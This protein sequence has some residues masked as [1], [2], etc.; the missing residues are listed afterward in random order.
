MLYQICPDI[1]IIS[2]TWERKRI[3]LTNL[4][5]KTKFNSISY[6]RQ[7]RSGGGC[8]IIFNENRFNVEELNIAIPEGV[9]ATWGVLQCKDNSTQKF[10]VNKI[11][12]GGVY[13]SPKSKFKIETID[14]IIETIHYARAKFGNEVHFLLGGDFNRVDVN[15]ILDAYG[16]L[17][18]F[19]SVP[20]RK[21][22]ILE[23][24]LTDLHPFY[25]PPTTLAPLEVDPDKNGSNS[26]HD[27]VLLAPKSNCKFKD[28]R[29]KKTVIT[30]PIPE[31]GIQQFGEEITAHKWNEVIETENVDEK[32]ENFHSYI[33]SLLDKHLPEKTIT[34]S[35]LDRKWMSGDLK[36]LLRKKQRE[37]VKHRKSNK[38]KKI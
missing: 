22:A 19:N 32:A 37:F 15:D 28:E 33:R 3:T 13:V 2:E 36:T 31:T 35:S 6:S 18:Q 27:V 38:W 12:V 10:K 1:A 26:D 11:V 21:D 4:L 24:L 25:H 29:I 5:E 16:A 14:H 34:I 23:L 30:R 8:A 9:E 17:K 7:G 20:T